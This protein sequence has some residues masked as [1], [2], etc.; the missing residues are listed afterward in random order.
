MGQAGGI[1]EIHLGCAASE[2]GGKLLG[3]R[4]MLLT[5]LL[6]QKARFRASFGL[7]HARTFSALS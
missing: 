7:T 5:A 3:Q 1:K 4:P 6:Y 2:H